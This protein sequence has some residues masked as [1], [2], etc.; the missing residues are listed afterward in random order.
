M[1]RLEKIVFDEFDKMGITPTNSE[2]KMMSVMANAIEKWMF[3]NFADALQKW[4]VEDYE[5]ARRHFE[6]DMYKEF[7]N[8]FNKYISNEPSSDIDKINIED[9][10]YEEL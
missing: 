5:P 9:A 10:N 8:T 2:W 7:P 3:D 1:D 4:L 6:Y